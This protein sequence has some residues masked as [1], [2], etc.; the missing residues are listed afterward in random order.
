M[1]SCVGEH[2]EEQHFQRKTDAHVCGN[3][4]FKDTVIINWNP[5]RLVRFTTLQNKKH[6]PEREDHIDD[7]GAQFFGS[8]KCCSQSIPHTR[9]QRM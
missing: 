3:M 5:P 1:A 9:S 7:R 8:Q 4:E 6:L 2:V